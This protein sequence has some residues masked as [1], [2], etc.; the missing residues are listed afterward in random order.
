[1]LTSKTLSDASTETVAAK[2]SSQQAQQQGCHQ[3]G[4]KAAS[5]ARS[6]CKHVSALAA[7]NVVHYSYATELIVKVSV[8]A[9]VSACWLLH[10][11]KRA[12]TAHML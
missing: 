5:S 8:I 10:R 11:A 1:M 2:S 12:A 6:A 9:G 4:G 3:Q 7:F